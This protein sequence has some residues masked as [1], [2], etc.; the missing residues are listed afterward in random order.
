MNEEEYSISDRGFKCIDHCYYPNT[1]IIHPITYNKIQENNYPFCPV[2][3][4][5]DNGN[6]ILYDK[7]SNPTKDKFETKY[8]LNI[9][10]FNK[11]EF[12]KLYGIITFEDAI[13]WINNSSHLPKN[14]LKRNINCILTVFGN[15]NVLFT[16]PIIKF[17]QKMIKK[18]SYKQT[19]KLL[20]E[21]SKKNKEA[22]L[23]KIK[24][25]IKKS[26]NKI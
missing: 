17:I 20:I 24:N 4:V 16:E 11:K 2:N 25:F 18:T 21:Y 22:D 8:T 1:F 23:F 26:L 9:L 14:T 6:Y 10:P 15:N 19:E 3:E 13:K 7:C 12:L 5:D